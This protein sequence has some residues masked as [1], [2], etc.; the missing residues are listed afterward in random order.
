[1]HLVHNSGIPGGIPKFIVIFSLEHKCFHVVCVAEL[2]SSG[3]LPERSR[4]LTLW[5]VCPALAHISGCTSESVAG[6]Y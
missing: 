6:A 3:V 1:M 4:E 2:C 5:S